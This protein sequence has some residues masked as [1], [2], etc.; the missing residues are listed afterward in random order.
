MNR[1]YSVDIFF[2]TRYSPAFPDP[3]LPKLAWENLALRRGGPQSVVYG[4]NGGFEGRIVDGGFFFFFFFLER[5]VSYGFPLSK[6]E[7]ERTSITH[8]F[9]EAF[10]QVF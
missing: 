5:V 10:A 4:L 7:G 8:R 3:R 2:S 1:C 6:G 9:M